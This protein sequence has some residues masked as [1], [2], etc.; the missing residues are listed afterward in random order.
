MPAGRPGRRSGSH[1]LEL[2]TGWPVDVSEEAINAI[3]AFLM[4][5]A[6]F[7][8]YVFWRFLVKALERPRIPALTLMTAILGA[9]AFGAV[10]T[11]VV[12]LNTLVRWKTGQGLPPGTA[13]ALI[14]LALVVVS[15]VEIVFGLPQLRRWSEET[16]RFHVHQRDS[17]PRITPHRRS[18]DPPAAGRSGPAS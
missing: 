7:P 11:G 1:S 2:T 9:V 15:I 18:D 14:A 12:G 8:V 6:P 10:I 5:I 13:L 4:V 17:E 3:A 16:R